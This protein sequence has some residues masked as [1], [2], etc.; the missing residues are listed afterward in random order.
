MSTRAG[1]LNLDLSGK[2]ALVCGAS[3]GIGEA[4]ARALA[5]QGAKV[6]A[7]AR[8]EEKLKKLVESL[9][10]SGH[11]FIACDVNDHANLQARLTA[12]LAASGGSIE[13]LVNNSAGPKGGP[14]L[15]AGLGEFTA[16]FHQH[17]ITSQ[18]LAQTLIPGMKAKNFGRIINVISTSVRIPIAGLGV[19]NTVRAAVASWAKTLSLEVAPFG[20]TVNSV[21]PGYTDTQRLSALMKANAEKTGRSEAAVAEEWKN[22]TPAKRFGKPEETAA[23]I[24]FLASPSAGFITGVAL[25]V[26]GG[27]IGAI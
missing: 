3:A 18:L 20:I 27:R 16:A 11:R 21:L 6:I 14:V 17:L 19:S 4:A 25:P 15:D 8:T 5:E 26:D 24:A 23:A 9:P 13:I 12:E 10:G 2:T 1:I 22:A 7:L